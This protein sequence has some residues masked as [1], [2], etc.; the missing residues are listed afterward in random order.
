MLWRVTKYPVRATSLSFLESRMVLSIFSAFSKASISLLNKATS[1]C[2]ESTANKG[3][4]SLT[5]ALPSAVVSLRACS[6]ASLLL[7][8]DLKDSLLSR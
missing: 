3:V 6:I 4:R 2:I 1:L 7:A 5:S 8:A